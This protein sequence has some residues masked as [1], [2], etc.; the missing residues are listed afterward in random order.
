MVNEYEEGTFVKLDSLITDLYEAVRNRYSIWKTPPSECED[1]FASLN[2][3]KSLSDV[4]PARPMKKF[5]PKDRRDDP[6]LAPYRTRVSS[7]TM[8]MITY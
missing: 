7:A 6:Q 8:N 1:P 5:K 3:P 4:V 2:L